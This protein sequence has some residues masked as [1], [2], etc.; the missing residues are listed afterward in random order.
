MATSSDTLETTS[1]VPLP[2]RC[3]YQP[4]SGG[5]RYWHQN[6]HDRW[7]HKTSGQFS[8]WLVVQGLAASISTD[9]YKAGRVL[10][11]VDELMTQLE[12]NRLIDYAG[13]LAGWRAGVYMMNRAQVLVTQD[14]DL[15]EPLAPES[16][17]ADEWDPDGWSFP[18]LGQFLQGLFNGTER[19]G[20]R[21]ETVEQLSRF[22]CWLW[23][24]LSSIYSAEYSVGMALALAGEPECGKTLLAQIINRLSGGVIAR[25]Y[26][27]MTGQDNFNEECLSANLLLVDDENS[28]THITQ[29]LEFAA[30]LKQLVASRGT[31]IR[32]MHQKAMELQPIQRP[33]INV[34]LEPERLQV[35]PPIDNDIRDKI[36]VLKGYSKPMPMPARTPTE[37]K[38]FWQTM[39]DEMPYFLHWLLNVYQPD[40]NELGRFGPLAWQH[41]AILE[42]LSKLNPEART[43]EFIQRWL[44]KAQPRIVRSDLERI[45][46]SDK[47]RIQPH[48]KEN[49]L[50]GWIGTVSELRSQLVQDGDGAPLSMLERKEVRAVAYLGRDLSA[51]SRRYPAEIFQSRTAGQGGRN[52]VILFEALPNPEEKADA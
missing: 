13:G 48:L 22:T 47:V 36:L 10:S 34:N 17:G 51:L 19:D 6:D 11:E 7:V 24:F 12:T 27:Y 32:G 30:Q 28:N 2:Q 5:G 45:A 9:E 42:E 49:Q 25:P 14:P 44:K 1:Q 38:L 20:D 41:P 23:H 26:R 52:W 21:E 15:I 35:L 31:R 4:T 40:D 16:F 37:Q 39:E 8:R 33:M 29:R 3:W 50:P 46:V 43:E 18:V